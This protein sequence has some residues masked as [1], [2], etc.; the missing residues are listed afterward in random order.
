MSAR[1][2]AFK[3][4]YIYVGLIAHRVIMGGFLKGSSINESKN[5]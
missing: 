1:S 5:N 2:V 4:A 3:L